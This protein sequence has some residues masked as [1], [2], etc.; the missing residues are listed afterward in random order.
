MTLRLIISMTK[1]KTVKLF[2]FFADFSKA[3]DIVPRRKLLMVM[4]GLGPLG[5]RAV[6]LAAVVPM[7][8]T[9]E[10]VIGS[11]VLIVSQG[12]RQGSPT[13]CL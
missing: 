1:L 6:M 2:V 11:A 10:S 12:V 3:Y 8:H 7:Y 4:K 9:T 13:A 5:C